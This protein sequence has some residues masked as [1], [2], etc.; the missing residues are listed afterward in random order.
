MK[1]ELKIKL[2]SLSQKGL[3]LRYDQD[4]AELREKLKP[5]IGENSYNI[6]VDIQSFDQSSYIISGKIETQ[7]NLLCA[8]CAYEF[9]KPINKLFKEKIIIQKKLERIDKSVRN[10]HFSELMDENW[11]LVEQA[12]FDLGDFLYELI[13]IEE[14][15]RPLNSDSC[16]KDYSNC[17]HL[18][19]MKEQLSQNSRTQVYFS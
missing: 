3:K 5:L 10:N 1:S 19:R 15:L 4:S 11:T 6:Q 2:K 12:L 13:A 17:K 14:P 8:R 9:K 7:I 16:D 18:K